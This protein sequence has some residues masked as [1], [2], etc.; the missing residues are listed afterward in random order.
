[1]PQV[2]VSCADHSTEPMLTLH[3]QTASDFVDEP[4][5]E[6][7][8]DARDTVEQESA[9]LK[10]SSTKEAIWQQEPGIAVEFDR[11]YEQLACAVGTLLQQQEAWAA[12]NG[13]QR[14]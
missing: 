4:A 1:M 7:T 11:R 9:T 8:A 5:I 13:K 14:E 2:R 12:L 6:D 10:P 3:R